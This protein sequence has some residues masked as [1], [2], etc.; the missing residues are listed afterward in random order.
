[1]AKKWQ[2][3]RK[4]KPRQNISFVF[5]EKNEVFSISFSFPSLSAFPFLL[6][7]TK[8]GKKKKEA[9]FNSFVRQGISAV[10]FDNKV[11]YWIITF[12]CCPTLSIS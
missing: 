6:Y 7:S 3:M 11:N 1:M 10:D 5:I 4:G 9:N 12:S 2:I 8:G